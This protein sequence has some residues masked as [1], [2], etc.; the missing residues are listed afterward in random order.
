MMFRQVC[1]RSVAFVLLAVRCDPIRNHYAPLF[2]N[3]AFGYNLNSGSRCASYGRRHGSNRK[4]QHQP[5]HRIHRNDCSPFQQQ[6]QQRVRFPE[7]TL[8]GNHDTSVESIWGLPDDLPRRE[9]VMVAI[10]AVRRACY[11]T[12][13]L[14]PDR[15]DE[16]DIGMVSKADL[17]PVTVADFA[18]QGLILK[19]LNDTYPDDGFIAEDSTLC[20]LVASATN[21]D[22]TS[23]MNAIDLGKSYKVWENMD[24]TKQQQ[25]QRPSRVWVL[26][27]IDG[28]KGFLRGRTN[29]GQYAIALALLNEHGIPVI[30][31][32]GCPNLPTNRDDERYRWYDEE[33]FETN[34]ESR[35]CIFAASRG[36]GCYQLQ[37]HSTS[38]KCQRIHV[39][40]DTD[41][42]VEDARFCIGV[43]RYSD[44][45]GYCIAM[46]KCIH[47][48]ERA[49][50]PHSGDIIRSRRMDSQAKHGVL[51][52]GGAELYAR[53]PKPGYVEWIWDHAAGNVVIEEAGGQMS[54]VLGR[55]IDFS[56]GAQLSPDVHGVFVS[57]GGKFHPALVDAYAAASQVNAGT[58]IDS[59]VAKNA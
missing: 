9:D 49:L 39:T 52:R 55:P 4:Q 44:A 43:E 34:Q 20:H 28:T 7:T 29:G 12:A 36:G 5:R 23:V 22:P 47:G 13:Q 30:G 58:E 57:A 3:G 24:P 41:R 32:L 11:I 40:T 51:A 59:E 19:L 33:T 1:Q 14:Q 42:S 18:V 31:V 53:L 27:P 35:G 37:L 17:S 54:D 2:L 15:S 45:L 38:T 48:L 10:D 21:L 6:Q 56:L 50:D 26:D 16:K 46:A 8:H 25:Q